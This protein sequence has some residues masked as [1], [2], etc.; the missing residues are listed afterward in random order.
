MAVG[1]LSSSAPVVVASV[2]A[3]GSGGSTLL[4]ELF[5]TSLPVAPRRG[6][7]TTLGVEEAEAA[8]SQA[9]VLDVEGFDSRCVGR[10]NLRVDLWDTLFFVANWDG[11]RSTWSVWLHSAMGSFVLFLLGRTV[12]LPLVAFGFADAGAPIFSS[13]PVVYRFL[14]ARHSWNH[15]PR[16]M[17]FTTTFFLSSG[18][19]VVRR[20]RR[21]Q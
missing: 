16:L 4:N 6:V 14:S 12:V 17:L 8:S 3:C 7:Q 11:L 15:D 5:Q 21:W 13:F 19:G 18:I 10:V 2:G 1:T 9:V 20:T